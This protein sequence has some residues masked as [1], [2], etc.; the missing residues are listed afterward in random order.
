ML[1]LENFAKTEN[2]IKEINLLMLE[3]LKVA[4]QQTDT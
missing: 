1:D 2:S 3:H 4:L